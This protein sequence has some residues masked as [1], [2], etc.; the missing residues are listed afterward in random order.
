MGT[1]CRKCLLT[2]K[3]EGVTIDPNGLCDLCAGRKRDE[4]DVR[5]EVTDEKRARL[6]RELYE[7][8]EASRGQGEYDCLL[9][10]S[11]GKDSAYLLH[12]LMVE[13]KLRV[14]PLHVK[15]PFES[16]IGQENLERLQQKLGVRFEVVEPGLD[17]YRAFYRTLFMNPLRE[18]YIKTVCYVCG[19]HFMGLALQKA[20]EKGI[21]VVA[22]GLSPYQPAN[23]FFEWGPEIVGRDWTPDIF[24]TGEL[25]DEVRRWFWNP[26]R[27]PEG[28]R[29]PRLLAP[30]HVMEYST[31]DVIARLDREG[32][33]PRKKSNPAITNCILN[34]PMIMLDRRL[35]GYNPYLP[36]MSSVVRS[37]KSSRTFWKGLFAIMD[38]QLKLG[39][40]K[41]KDIRKVEQLLDL[42]FS[43]CI[44]DR[45]AIYRSYVEYP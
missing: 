7:T 20:T 4:W 22:E 38:L 32:I 31:D 25:G 6:R 37:G 43:Q 39:I 14:L 35:L 5:F 29:L 41:T 15:T 36:E 45:A 28:T 44:T 30:L 26:S 13:K 42:D 24:K 10:V 40:F 16:P 17:F 9:T 23:M 18:G 34:W 33:L 27:Y 12:H 19:P 3:V 8:L 2:R 11:G 1:S 21:P